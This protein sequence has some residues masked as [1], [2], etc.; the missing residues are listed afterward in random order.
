MSRIGTHDHRSHRI[1]GTDARQ[2]FHIESAQKRQ[3][4]VQWWKLPDQ[5]GGSPGGTFDHGRSAV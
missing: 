1:D 2:F 3:T 5:S 4:S